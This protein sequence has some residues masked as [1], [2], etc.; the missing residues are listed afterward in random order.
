M[1]RGRA[2]LEG[3]LLPTSYTPL[4]PGVTKPVIPC[5]LGRDVQAGAMVLRKSRYSC[6]LAAGRV[7]A[8]GSAGAWLRSSSLEVP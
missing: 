5:A 7:P 3:G 8:N 4:I 2:R 6:I 1:P